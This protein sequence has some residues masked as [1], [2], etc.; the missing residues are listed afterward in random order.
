[1]LR[2]RS[3]SRPYLRKNHALFKTPQC[4]DSFPKQNVAWMGMQQQSIQATYKNTT[5]TLS[6]LDKRRGSHRKG[7]DE[8]NHG[9][10]PRPYLCAR[11]STFMRRLNRVAGSSKQKGVWMYRYGLRMASSSKAIPRDTS[12][13]IQRKVEIRLIKRLAGRKVPH[14]KGPG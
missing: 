8:Q 9:R 12:R 11:K 10:T 6:T 2:G 7:L 14:T 1:M 4:R 5:L 13:P 3:S